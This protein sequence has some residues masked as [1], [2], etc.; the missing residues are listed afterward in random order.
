MAFPFLR[1]SGTLP[2]LCG[3]LVI[4][5]TG[6]GACA[7]GGGS[8][9]SYAVAGTAAIAAMLLSALLLKN[10]V[11]MPKRWRKFLRRK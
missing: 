11:P 7:L 8:W 1:R 5:A 4:L 2:R 3:L 10:E 6:V 9:Q